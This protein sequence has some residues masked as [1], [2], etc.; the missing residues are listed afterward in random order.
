[1]QVLFKAAS[2]SYQLM[3]AKPSVAQN[4]AFAVVLLTTLTGRFFVILFNVPNV[5]YLPQHPRPEGA[6][7][8]ICFRVCLLR[9]AFHFWQTG[10]SAASHK[11]E[12]LE[13]VRSLK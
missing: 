4:S 6:K 13:A 5:L 2:L 11:Q 10:C 1:M 8:S 7:A 3:N 12:F 9:N